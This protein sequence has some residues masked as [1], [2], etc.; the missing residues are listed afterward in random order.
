ML[1]MQKKFSDWKAILAAS[2]VTA[3]QLVRYLPV[4]KE[5]IQQVIQRYP[6]RINPYYLSLICEPHDP[7]WK[8]AVPD[9]AEIGEQEG[10]ADP[11]LEEAHSPVPNLIHRYPDRV[12][13][14]V[15][16]QCA[17]YCRYCMRKRKVGDP[18]LITG[19]TIAAGLEYIREHPEVRDV[20]LS[21]GDPLLLD[22]GDL[23]R[24]LEHIRSI[25]HIEIIRI[26]TR[27]PCT[28]PQRITTNLAQI[29]KA[30]HPLFINIHINH[31]REITDA[32]GS[33]CH[34]LADAGIPLGCQTVLLKGVNDDAAVMKS[35]MQK[36]LKIR[37]KPYYLHHP[38]LV[39]GTR[40]FQTGLDV[41]LKIMDAL[42]GHTS[43]LCVPHYM[44]DLPG[45]GGKIPLLSEYVIDKKPERWLI[46]N[47]AGKVYE[48]PIIVPRND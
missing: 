23:H 3:D 43:G 40:H 26:H 13:F 44:V 18:F 14:L 19:Q 4:A 47:Y 6:L 45:G 34:M 41:G 16:G 21:G 33:A 27:V 37:V 29:L 1:S 30:F 35:L 2:V 31:P 39:R 15:S 36:L 32:S 42:R 10:I 5:Q 8:Q 24:I 28:L 25:A 9:I 38:D 20:I 22:D 48:Y 46:R 7:I 11:L 12:V 17:V